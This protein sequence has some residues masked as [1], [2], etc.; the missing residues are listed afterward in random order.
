MFMA[1]PADA[2]EELRIV[3]IDSSQYPIVEAVVVVPPL[4]AGRPLAAT[5]FD[6]R[7]RTVA[8]PLAVEP[9]DPSTLELAVVV[10]ASIGP[11]PLTAAQGGLLEIPVHLRE[12]QISLVNAANPPSVALPLTDDPRAAGAAFRAMTAR[13]ESAL[14]D[15]IDMALDQ[16][17]PDARWKAMVVVA[18]SAPTDSV[19]LVQAADRAESESVQTYVISVDA[20]PP[21]LGRVAFATGGE[22]MAIGQDG[23]LAAVD[24]V[25]TDLRGQYRVRIELSG[26]DPAAPVALA[27][28]AFGMTSRTP[29]PIAATADSSRTSREPSSTSPSQTPVVAL[30][31]A[32][33]LVVGIVVVIVAGLWAGSRT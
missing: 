3:T 15:G 32:G 17:S 18:G 20:V 19:R 11:E 21:E 8:R 6:V 31:L 2:D 33:L 1:A 22:A 5:H 24:D 12:P 29:L 14:E 30:A 26:D 9:L 7:E 28:S 27:V 4:M 23:F 10:D 13:Q 25:I 16:F